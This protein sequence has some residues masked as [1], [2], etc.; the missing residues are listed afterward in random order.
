MGLAPFQ[1]TVEHWPA[2]LLA[3]VPA[4][5]N[6]AILGYLAVR[7]K[8][9]ALTY[10]F[11]LFVSSL[12]VWQG[13]EALV[14]LSETR[15]SAAFWADA[16]A[17]G[18]LLIGPF[19]VHFALLFTE[20]RGAARSPLVWFLLY[21]PAIAIEA[22]SRAGLNQGT[23]VYREPWGWMTGLPVPLLGTL[24]GIWV[25]AL[26]F[27]TLWL[28]GGHA[29][30]LPP[31][32]PRRPQAFWVTIGFAV[33]VVQ[34]TVT[35]VLFPTFLG[36]EAIPVASTFMTTFS[37]CTLIALRRY[38]FLELPTV[39]ELLHTARVEA[40]RRS[41]ELV[42][43]QG[44]AHLGNWTWDVRANRVRWSDEMFRIYGYEAAF[45]MTFEKAMERVLPEDK[46]RTEASVADDLRQRRSGQLPLNEYRIRLPDGQVRT[47]HGRGRLELG[48]D[49]K[50]TRMVGTVQ[51]VTEQK[52]VERELHAAQVEAQRRSDD[53]VEAQRIAHL[54]NW[55][56]DI[57]Q[58][59]VTWSDEL[60]RIYGDEPGAFPVTYE[61]FLERV[62]PDDRPRVDATIQGAFADHQPFEFDH[63]I[64]LPDGTEKTLHA[65]GSVTENERHEPVRMQGI[66]Q[67]IT[68]RR[69]AEVER[70]R[71]ERQQ[72]ELDLLKSEN[73]FKAQFINMAAH[74]LNTPLT[75]LKLQVH[76]LRNASPTPLTKDQAHT[77]DILD[78]N[79]DRVAILVR[80][81]L[82]VGRIQSGRIDLQKEPL[83]LHGVVQHAVDSFAEAAK[84]AGV[85]LDAWVTGEIW[86]DADALRVNQVLFNL[87]SNAL[88][89]TP[90]GGRIL[91]EATLQGHDACV[92]VRDTGVGLTESQINRLFQPFTQVHEHPQT[93]PKPGTGL[94]LFISRELAALHGGRLV[95][96]SAG[97]G[98]G[99]TFTLT[100]P[101]AHGSTKPA[102]PVP[103][104]AAP[105]AGSGLAVAAAPQ[106]P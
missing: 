21:G 65:K 45:P 2:V 24:T 7:S 18:A 41:E 34:G 28:L 35:Q 58:N 87:V 4:A 11:L 86:V 82:D 48:R 37:V 5:L 16:L 84:Q 46:A 9:N 106:N 64:V 93:A 63:R 71:L 100:L 29:W 96:E 59:V 99:S 70:Q 53:L 54:G 12:V 43:A 72:N 73:N 85:E 74:E 25:A 33:P 62:H 76:L 50:P 40:Q 78:R 47:L 83:D 39:D 80:N 55:T 20:R 23:Q 97:P 26:A 52:A 79:L 1:F 14:R 77:L 91:V 68:E 94:G 103:S 30:K 15:E 38:G 95:V 88:K 61:R 90:G 66:G 102:A 32:N 42:E 10:S 36:I 19:G 17:A 6:L 51:D 13:S 75:P 27:A 67:D 98:H 92:K 56:W 101:A 57:P 81:M 44:I 105:V 49:G 8:K 3:L 89:F 60:Y 104:N 31:G 22:L 69:R